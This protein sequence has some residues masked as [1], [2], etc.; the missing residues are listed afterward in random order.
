MR[1]IFILF[2][3]LL[4]LASCDKRYEDGPC[5]SFISPENR[6]A[7][8]WKVASLLI[9][10]VDQTAVSNND[11]LAKC[12]ISFFRD[13]DNAMFVSLI[14]SS[15]LVWAE[16]LVRTDDRMIYL[17]FGLATIEG[18]EIAIE[19]IFHILPALATE[20]TWKI[21]KLKRTEM[22]IETEYEGATHEL[23]FKLLF[24]YDNL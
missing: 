15:N 17:T 23:R 9:N 10:G 5:I 11:S 14:D 8:R 19:P 4:S 20:K 12:S 22:W 24:D 16:S 1:R 7:G 21:L 18:Y 2:F 13:L 3:L 6:I